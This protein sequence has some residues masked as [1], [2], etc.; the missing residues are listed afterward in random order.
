MASWSHGLYQYNHESLYLNFY[1]KIARLTNR[2]TDSANYR[3]GCR[4]LKSKAIR[5]VKLFSI[6]VNIF[7]YPKFPACL[8]LYFCHC[9]WFEASVASAK[10]KHME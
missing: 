10:F 8:F 1:L 3:D 4:R 2:L 7:L 9:K 5:H 6:N